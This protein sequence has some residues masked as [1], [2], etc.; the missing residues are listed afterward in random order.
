MASP[1]EFHEIGAWMIAD[2]LKIQGWDIDYLG[3]NTPQNDLIKFLLSSLPDILL[4]S[5]TMLFN[6]EKVKEI[7]DS[8]KTN[9][10]LNKMKIMVGGRIFIEN[11]ELGIT[12]GADGFGANIEDAKKLAGQW[13][14]I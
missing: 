9:T 14:R 1:N 13:E 2:I 4:I 6:V 11:P 7:I 10:D 5:V 12:L 8:I 3:A